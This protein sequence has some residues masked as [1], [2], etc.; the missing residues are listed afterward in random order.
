MTQVILN[1]DEIDRINKLFDL[2][3]KKDIDRTQIL[4]KLIDILYATK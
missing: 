3:D 4:N 2:Y 1:L